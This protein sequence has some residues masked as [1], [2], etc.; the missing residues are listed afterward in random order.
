MQN[1]KKHES[2]SGKLKTEIMEGSSK[3]LNSWLT[4]T[5]RLRTLRAMLMNVQR[6]SR[7]C[8][9]SMARNLLWTSSSKILESQ[10][11]D[12]R[13]S[14]ARVMDRAN[15]VSRISKEMLKNSPLMHSR[16]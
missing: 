15:M 13:S 7:K 14:I 4:W 9:M 2:F 6:T 5:F 12:S 16:L 1:R 10:G 8:K 11:L 3:G